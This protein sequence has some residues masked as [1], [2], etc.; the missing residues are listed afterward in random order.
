MSGERTRLTQVVF[1][2]FD[3][4]VKYTDPGSNISLTVERDAGAIVRCGSKPGDRARKGEII[5]ELDNTADKVEVDAA[6]KKPEHAGPIRATSRPAN[7]R[8]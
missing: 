8:I 4:A 1:N 6:G 7:T 5:A 2:L 3:N